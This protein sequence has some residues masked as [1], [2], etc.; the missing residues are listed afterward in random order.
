[1]NNVDIVRFSILYGYNAFLEQGL[2]Y[3]ACAFIWI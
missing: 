1:M 3:Y 2:T